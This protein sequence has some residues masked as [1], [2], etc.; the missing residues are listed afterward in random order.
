L[1][2]FGCRRIGWDTSL[3]EPGA[4]C[5]ED[6]KRITHQIVDRP[7]LPLPSPPATD[8]EADEDGEGATSRKSNA[9]VPG[10]VYVQPQWVWDSINAG[11]LQRPD[12]YAPG[13]TLPPHLSP[14]VKPKKGEYD[15]TVSLA[16][17]ETAAEVDAAEAADELAEEEEESEADEEDADAALEEASDGEEIDGV[18]GDGEAENLEDELS[19][20]NGGMDV[21]LA[22]SDDDEEEASA[23][24]KAED[25][26]WGGLSGDED[27]AEDAMAKS[28]REH[29][30]E[31]EAEASGRKVSSAPTEAEKRKAARQA[32]QTKRSK[33]E[34][35]QEEELE[36]RKMM[37]PRRKRKMYEKMVYSN[38]R[39]DEEAEKLRA[40][41]RKL[42]KGKA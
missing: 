11:K 36:R 6:D 31:L 19:D 23:P 7:D 27:G 39:K 40:K 14:W 17:Q 42:E 28:G 2:S 30:A 29:Q 37:M 41:K 34:R 38:A 12:I 32:S 10:R 5:G 35:E 8:G 3:G 21:A 33:A 15:P 20:E 25:D 24:G 9:R 26:E 16:E 1:R 22:G 13:A 18:R 4:Y